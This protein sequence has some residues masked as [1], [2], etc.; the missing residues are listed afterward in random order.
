MCRGVAD[1]GG[2]D[3]VTLTFSCHK[4]NHEFQYLVHLDNDNQNYKFQFYLELLFI[5]IYIYNYLIV[6]IINKKLGFLN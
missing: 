6:F 1:G 5:I 2:R 4:L 3:Q